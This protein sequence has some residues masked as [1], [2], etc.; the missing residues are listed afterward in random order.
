MADANRIMYLTQEELMALPIYP[1]STG[2]P[3]EDVPVG[4][5]WRRN[6]RKCDPWLVGEW[7]GK[8]GQLERIIWREVRICTTQERIRMIREEKLGEFRPS[9]SSARRSWRRFASF[10]PRT[11]RWPRT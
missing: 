9:R 1:A 7:T 8:I 10:K 6:D 11:S 3:L 5:L 2:G 4:T